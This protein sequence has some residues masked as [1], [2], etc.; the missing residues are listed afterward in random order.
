MKKW[1]LS[2]GKFS[3]IYFFFLFLQCFLVSG[4][5]FSAST[6]QTSS[7]IPLSHF[8]LFPGRKRRKVEGKTCILVLKGCWG[9]FQGKK[10]SDL[11]LLP[12]SPKLFPITIS[13]TS[14]DVSFPALV[15][16]LCPATTETKGTEQQHMETISWS[17]GILMIH[18]IGVGADVP[19]LPNLCRQLSPCCHLGAPEYILPPSQGHLTRQSQLLP[20][21]AGTDLVPKAGHAASA[22]HNA[23]GIIL[24]PIFHLHNNVVSN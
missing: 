20:S 1:P 14:L 6:P 19:L 15:N 24:H 18:T 7:V 8:F 11:R 12:A 16:T 5:T 23:R 22:R 9:F 21:P 2:K 3:L 10:K 4:R 13:T 17:I